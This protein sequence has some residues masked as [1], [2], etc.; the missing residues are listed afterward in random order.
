M[1]NLKFSI[2][3]FESESLRVLNLLN[4]LP[5]YL[6]DNFTKTGLHNK[7]KDHS[8]EDKINIIKNELD[9][10]AKRK[11]LM[12]CISE[13]GQKADITVPKIQVLEHR[14]LSEHYQEPV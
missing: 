4:F 5:D 13:S 14:Q 7:L 1:A 8:K 2:E 9:D 10:N 6:F 3:T 11:E 12:V